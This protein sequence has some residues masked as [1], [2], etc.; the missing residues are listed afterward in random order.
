[1]LLFDSWYD[2]YRGVVCIVAIKDGTVRIGQETL[3]PIDDHISLQHLCVQ[4][5][6]SVLLTVDYYIRSPSWVC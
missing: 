1:M 2:Q 5:M 3:S 6:L 4:E